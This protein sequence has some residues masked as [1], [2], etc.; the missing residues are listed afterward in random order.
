MKTI[1]EQVV[2]SMNN[3]AIDVLYN[4]LEL[5]EESYSSCS[6]LYDEYSFLKHNILIDIQSIMD[7]YL[8]PIDLYI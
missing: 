2:E 4:R 3:Q 6:M 7:L 5:I 1:A 8:C